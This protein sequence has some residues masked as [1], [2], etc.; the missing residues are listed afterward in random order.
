[1]PGIKDF[2]KVSSLEPATAKLQERLQEFFVPFVN[3]EI[4][5]GQI[6]K[7]VQLTTG[8][9]NTIAH[10]LGR[11]LLG[12]TVIRQRASAIIWDEQDTN[13]LKQRNLILQTSANV[14]VDLWVF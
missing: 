1:M 2:K 3:C 13:T 12:L 10:L 7:N 5:D 6:L 4:I 9:P 11:E 14:T 8:A